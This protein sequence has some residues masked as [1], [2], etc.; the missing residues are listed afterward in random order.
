MYRQ[1]GYTSP[2]YLDPGYST[3]GNLTISSKNM[4]GLDE[5]CT[6]NLK[7]L[8][9][10]RVSKKLRKKTMLVPGFRHPIK[11]RKLMIDI[12]QSLSIKIYSKQAS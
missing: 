6:Q 5:S 4:Q 8:E 9:I 1:S 3:N 12:N 7:T 11:S 2:D 10:P